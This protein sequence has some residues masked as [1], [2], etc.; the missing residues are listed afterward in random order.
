[1][2]DS[3]QVTIQVVI[4][5]SGFDRAADTLVRLRYPLYCVDRGDC[6]RD[7]QFVGPF[8]SHDAAHEQAG[9]GDLVA[10]CRRLKPSEIGFAPDDVLDWPSVSAIR[11]VVEEAIDVH[12]ELPEGAWFTV[13]GKGE[14]YRPIVTVERDDGTLPTPENAKHWCDEHLSVDVYICEGSE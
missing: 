3:I 10:R 1:M 2:N 9:L 14:K 8:D 4:D 5:T 7:D 12:G 13:M 11:D 6:L